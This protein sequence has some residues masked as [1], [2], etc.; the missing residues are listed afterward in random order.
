MQGQSSVLHWRSGSEAQREVEGCQEP[1][2]WLRLLT[3][4]LVWPAFRER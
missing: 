2:P 4:A 3:E 1:K